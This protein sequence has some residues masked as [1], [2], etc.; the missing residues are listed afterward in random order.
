MGR[1][2]VD[3]DPFIPSLIVFLRRVSGPNVYLSNLIVSSTLILY[4][5]LT[6]KETDKLAFIYLVPVKIYLQQMVRSPFISVFVLTLVRTLCVTHPPLVSHTEVY[7]G[8]RVRVLG[9][10]YT[11]PEPLGHIR[12]QTRM[13]R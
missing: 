6:D 10:L 5:C 13:S 9:H 11:R 7:S 2:D 1:V 3:E 12:V 4:L 8:G